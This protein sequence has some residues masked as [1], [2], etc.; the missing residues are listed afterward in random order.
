MTRQHVDYRRGEDRTCDAFSLDDLEERLRVK[1]LHHHGAGSL[2]EGRRGQDP[3]LVRKR[4]YVKQGIRVVQ[5][6]H[7]QR[8]NV[9]VGVEPVALKVDGAFV[10]SG[11]SG[12]VE[13]QIYVVLVY[14]EWLDA[15][16][17][18]DQLLVGAPLAENQYLEIRQVPRVPDPL[19][20]LYELRTGYN[21]L[22]GQ[23]FQGDGP[24]PFTV[25][26][27]EPSP[28]RS[29]HRD[30]RVRF[31]PFVAVV[32][33]RNDTVALRD[34]PGEQ[35]TGKACRA[36]PQFVIGEQ[37]ARVHERDPVPMTIHRFAHKVMDKHCHGDS[38]PYLGLAATVRFKCAS[39]DIASSAIWGTN[40][41]T[42]TI[43]WMPLAT[44]PAGRIPESRS[45]SSSA[46]MR[47]ASL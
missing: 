4:A 1:M 32:H 28:D 43:S 21:D 45:P 10:A 15:S 29:D 41:A 12:R 33:D 5:S 17:A 47:A 7:E 18:F 11:R 30:G 3:R 22:R 39:K 36:A 34:P 9:A 20:G 19:E 6:T 14:G 40:A 26:G 38:S 27:V 2:V 23:I 46:R 16:R 44:W 37:A 31:H 24:L 13:D 35:A 42:D 25:P 8:H